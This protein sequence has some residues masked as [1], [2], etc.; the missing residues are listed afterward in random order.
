MGIRH[1]VNNSGTIDVI[2]LGKPDNILI[3]KLCG[4]DRKHLIYAINNDY[5]RLFGML[6]SLRGM[7]M[8]RTLGPSGLIWMARSNG[9]LCGIVRFIYQ[10]RTYMLVGWLLMLGVS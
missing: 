8:V 7:R 6:R 9:R 4:S 5:N 1:S 10:A 3:G 2:S